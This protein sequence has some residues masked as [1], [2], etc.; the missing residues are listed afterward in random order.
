MHSRPQD[1]S[2]QAGPR[3]TP[4]DSRPQKLAPARPPTATPFLILGIVVVALN[5]RPTIAGFGPLLA[6]IQAELHVNAATVSLLTTIPLLCWGLLAPLAPLLTRRRSSETVILV[7]TAV[8]GVGALLRVGPSLPWI[9]LGTVLIGAG[10]AIINVLLPSLVKRD[11]P[12]RVGLMTGVYTLAVVSGAALASGLAVPLRGALGGSW[13]ASL[14]IWVWLAA[15]GVLAWLPALFGRQTHERAARQGPGVWRNPY[16][17]PVTLF[18]GFQGLV[19]FTWLTWLPR[20]LQ[21]HGLSA[22]ASGL[23][24]SAGNVVQLP[25]TLA[26]PIL[27]ARLRNPALLVAGAAALIGAGLLGL[28]LAPGWPLPW[29]LLLGAGCGSTFPLALVFIAQRAAHPAQ[30]PQLSALAQGF[31]YLLAAT[32]PFIF[33]ALHDRTHGWNAPL[34]FLLVCT[35]LTLVTGLLA[36]WPRRFP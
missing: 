18:M 28:L 31:G 25:F 33:G 14:G 16:A 13:R 2:Q 34:G 21:D 29:I 10:I 32:G 9:L 17:L 36:S 22:A 12:E 6:Q 3:A 20:V 23:L 24:L 35:G 5:L 11:F 8:I 4:E 27:A 19:F 26:V 30:V 1:I 15:A 7:S